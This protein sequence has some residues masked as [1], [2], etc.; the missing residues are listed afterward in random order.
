M[1]IRSYS[2]MALATMLLAS[3]SYGN[4]AAYNGAMVGAT[5][6]DG[7]GG[8]LGWTASG[9]DKMGGVMLGR[10]LGTA[11]GAVIGYNAAK[12]KDGKKSAESAS[13]KDDY[14]LDTDTY[15]R[16]YE[17]G[18]QTY[19]PDYQTSGG[20]SDDYAQSDSYGDTYKPGSTKKRFA[21]G[22]LEISNLSYEDENGDGRISKNETCNI[23]YKVS[24]TSADAFDVV[25]A[26]ED[27]D[28][29]GAYAISPETKVRLEGHKTIRYTA[30][31]YCKKSVSGAAARFRVS[32]ASENHGSASDMIKIKA[33]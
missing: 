18:G 15:N 25:L 20:Y 2:V 5:I 8:F 14:Y 9:R 30:K 11:A 22:D 19:T 12:P 17:G 32:V 29:T 27:M 6:G 3:C 23:V 21:L 33:D 4:Y 31:V 1:T 24:N 13:G 10:A 28:N 26:V 7:I 16:R